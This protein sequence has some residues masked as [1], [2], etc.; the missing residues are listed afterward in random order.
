MNVISE[1]NKLYIGLHDELV[2][3]YEYMVTSKQDNCHVTLYYHLPL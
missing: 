1:F 3:K 2:Y